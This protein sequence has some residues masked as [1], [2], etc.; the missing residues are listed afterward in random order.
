MWGLQRFGYR[1]GVLSTVPAFFVHLPLSAKFNRAVSHIPPLSELWKLRFIPLLFLTSALTF[2]AFKA[3]RFSHHLWN[4]RHFTWDSKNPAFVLISLFPQ[5]EWTSKGA[6]KGTRRL[7]MGT[8]GESED[9]FLTE[10]KTQNSVKRY[11]VG[12]LSLGLVESFL[13]L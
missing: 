1:F 3:L 13:A 9:T 6:H 4:P 7:A 2:P 8:V 12:L 11:G 10:V 5:V